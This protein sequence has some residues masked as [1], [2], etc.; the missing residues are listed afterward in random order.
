MK[1]NNLEDVF[2]DHLMDLHSAEQQ[3]TSALPKMAGKVSSKELKDAFDRHVQ[4]TEEHLERLRRIGDEMGIDLKGKTCKA[5]QGLIKEGE[6]IMQDGGADDALDAALIAA[7]QRVEHYEIAAYGS[8]CTYA[9]ELGHDEALKLLKQTLDE[10]ERTDKQL[11]QI[12]EGGINQR[13]MRA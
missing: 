10:E 13:A 1:L 3:L 8:A 7:A 6:E 9:E 4:A 2:R 5:M 11:T 12:A